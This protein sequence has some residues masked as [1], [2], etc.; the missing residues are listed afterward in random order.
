M[1][2]HRHHSTPSSRLVHLLLLFGWLLSSHGIAPAICMAA[3]LADGDHAVKVG[4]SNEGAVTV[5]LSHAGKSTAELSHH[6]HDALC[7]VLIAFAVAP[8]SSASDHVLAFQQ[9]DDSRTQQQSA[10]Q[11][12]ANTAA[13]LLVM[14][15]TLSKPSVTAALVGRMQRSSWSRGLALKSGRTVMRC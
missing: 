5:V 4:V 3:A 12:L 2:A 11:D 15:C 14:D 1:F 8:E 13:P 6:E 10:I 7:S 9:V